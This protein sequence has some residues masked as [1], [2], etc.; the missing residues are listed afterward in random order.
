MYTD[1]AS[2]SL[3]LL[4][5]EVQRQRGIHAVFGIADE[6]ELGMAQIKFRTPPTDADAAE[7]ARW[8]QSFISELTYI[9]NNLDEENHT[10]KYNERNK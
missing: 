7:L 3:P 8:I 6:K 2:E 1:G 4:C 10:E 5:A 9:L